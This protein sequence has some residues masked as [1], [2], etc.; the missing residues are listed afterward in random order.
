MGELDKLEQEAKAIYTFGKSHIVLTI[1]L[2][3][4]LL[5]GIYTFDSRR[6]E[7]ADS[8]A[9]I[10]EANAKAAEKK[11]DQADA[12]NK[13]FQTD[14]AAKEQANANR[15]MQLQQEVDSLAKAMAQ[16]NIELDKRQKT[17]ATLPPT[18]LA[19]RWN[20]LTNVP[21]AVTTTASGYAVTQQGAV[22]T[23]Q[24][25]ESVPVLTQNVKDLTSTVDLEKQQI[26]LK[27]STIALE[28]ARRG[29]D[30]SACEAKLAAKDLDIK[31]RDAEIKDIKA[32]Q[33]KKSLKYMV[34]GGFIVE[35]FR[36]Y[37]TGKL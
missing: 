30:G 25:L 8:R 22:A 18:E 9:A 6:A 20:M 27:D 21:G 3:A 26:A 12:A 34:L 16:R 35:A 17:D 29:S 10:A 4:A 1:A 13:Q 32:N 37:A 23:V 33:R 31:A 36:V 15:V 5:F 24:A 14:A 11:A 19:G 2:A 28:I 7:R